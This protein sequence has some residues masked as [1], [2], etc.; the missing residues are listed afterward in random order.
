MTESKTWADITNHKNHITIEE[1]MAIDKS[2]MF[3]CCG[4]SDKAVDAEVDQCKETIAKLSAELKATQMIIEHLNK[5]NVQKTIS[6]KD[7]D[8]VNELHAAIRKR[9]EELIKVQLDRYSTYALIVTKML[10][11]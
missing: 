8:P 3:R 5:S 10:K 11:D 6:Q 7:G 4:G 1:A 2:S 9:K